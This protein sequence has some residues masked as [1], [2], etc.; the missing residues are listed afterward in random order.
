MY[1]VVFDQ[2]K[3]ISEACYSVLLVLTLIC[4]IYCVVFDQAKECL[5]HAIQY[6]RHDSTFNQLGKIYLMENDIE[7]AVEIYKRAV[8]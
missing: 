3:R 7:S 2:A 5:K 8:E 4:L 6:S 1:Y